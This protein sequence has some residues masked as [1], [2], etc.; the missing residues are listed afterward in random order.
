MTILARKIND[1]ILR[2]TIRLARDALRQ[3]G[4][5]LRRSKISILGVY[6]SDI[7]RNQ[8]FST[9]ELVDM[10]LRHAEEIL[11]YFKEKSEDNQTFRQIFAKA[12]S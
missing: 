11:T 1:G 3:C 10:Y 4:K 7:F 6:P 9:K 12:L 2:H 8:G 5:T